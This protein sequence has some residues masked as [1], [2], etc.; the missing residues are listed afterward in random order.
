MYNVCTL[1]IEIIFFQNVGWT[2]E[3]YTA[4]GGKKETVRCEYADKKQFIY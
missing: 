3:G 4:L 2:T 1:H